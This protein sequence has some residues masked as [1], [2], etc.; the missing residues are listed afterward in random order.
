[1]NERSSMHGAGAGDGAQER[2][3]GGLLLIRLNGALR[4]VRMYGSQSATLQQLLRDLLETIEALRD[5]EVSL[6]SMGDYFY[7]NSVRLKAQNSQV[8]LFRALM[9]EFEERAL[10][11]LRFLPGLTTTELESFLKLMLAASDATQGEQLPDE[12]TRAGMTHVIPVRAR[13]L[14]SAEEND[15]DPAERNPDGE[16]R[17][18]QRTF[19]RAVHGTRG[20]M[21]GAARSG[22]PALRQAR[23]LV[24]P[25]VDSLMKNEYSILGLTAL[26]EHDEYTYAHCVNV[27]VLSIGMGQVLGLSRQSLANLGVAGLLHDIGKVTVPTEVLQKPGKL[28]PEEWQLM[29][30]HPLEGLIMV[31]R[32]PGLTHLTVETMRVCFEHHMTVDRGGYPQI[33]HRGT[34]PSTLSRIVAAA[35]FFD[36]IT[37]HRAYRKRPLTPFEAL[38]MLLGGEREHFDPAVLW[39]LVQSVGLYPAG[40]VMM[41]ESR[42]VVLSISPNPADRRRPHCRVLVRP[43]GSTPPEDSPEMWDPMPAHENVA[44]VLQ[45]EDHAVP[46]GALLAA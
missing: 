4:G 19:W 18:A 29:R 22:R 26:K 10:G 46:A 3:L 11:G 7:V 43:D 5:D 20:I 35:D 33:P 6:I 30:R 34:T 15:D 1:M 36:A 40:T 16:R 13:D 39:A 38:S 12:A 32:M 45:P 8:A 28:S 31:S 14:K 27:S 25:M 23:R 21:L 24:Q 41:T 2:E 37:A 9:V 42:H 44:R 17:R